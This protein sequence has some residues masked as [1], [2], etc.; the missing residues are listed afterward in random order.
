MHTKH[1][2]K[3]ILFLLT[4]LAFLPCI[5]GTTYSWTATISVETNIRSITESA[6]D[7]TSWTIPPIRASYMKIP[8][9]YV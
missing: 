6:L 7:P 1:L 2:V 9:L 3:S 4:V 5:P 8:I